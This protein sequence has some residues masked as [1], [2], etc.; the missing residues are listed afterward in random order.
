[1]TFVCQPFHFFLD[2]RYRLIYSPF[3]ISLRPSGR[4]PAAFFLPARAVS[5]LS[6]LECALPRSLG[7]CTILVQISPLDS[8]LTKTGGG[9]AHAKRRNSEIEPIA[10]DHFRNQVI[11]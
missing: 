10:Q 5:Q 8:A 9:G 4:Q 11:R 6:P 3:R 7:F 1:M 2:I